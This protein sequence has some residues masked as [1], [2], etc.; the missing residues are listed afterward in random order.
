MPSALLNRVSMQSTSSA[1]SSSFSKSR[2]YNT[3]INNN[4]KNNIHVVKDITCYYIM[5][6][7]VGVFLAYPKHGDNN[8]SCSDQVSGAVGHHVGC[9]DSLSL[10]NHISTTLFAVRM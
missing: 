10:P 9:G 5:H 3:G 7:K 6:C 8:I 1:T 2:D 4:I